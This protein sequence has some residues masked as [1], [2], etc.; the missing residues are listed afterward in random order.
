[1]YEKLNRLEMLARDCWEMFAQM[2]K[3]MS[4]LELIEP[5]NCSIKA[6][7]VKNMSTKGIAS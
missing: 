3:S 2:E 7:E 1:M 4:A 5:S 6:I